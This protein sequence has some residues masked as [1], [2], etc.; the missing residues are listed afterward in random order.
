VGHE[1]VLGLRAEDVHDA[2]A[3]NDPDSVALAAVV[4]EVEYTGRRDLVT[5]AVGTP[6]VTARGSDVSGDMSGGATLRSFFPPRSMIRP[7]A[8]VTVAVKASSAH[9]FDAVT[10]RALWHP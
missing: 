4:R 7:G 9:V 10:G 5:V 1:V 2:T 3:G 6:P 8:A